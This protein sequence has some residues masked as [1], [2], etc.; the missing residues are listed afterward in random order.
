MLEVEAYCR[1][2][3]VTA[4]LGIGREGSHMCLSW[5]TCAV[6]IF[7]FSRRPTDELRCSI[8]LDYIY[9][10]S[11]HQP[12]KKNA[13]DNFAQSKK[14]WPAHSR[15]DGAQQKRGLDLDESL[16]TVPGPPA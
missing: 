13:R 3:V 5:C 6:V 12:R 7:I 4:N 10:L 9:L 8:S 14:K 11:Q 16:L 15:I 1:L 2:I